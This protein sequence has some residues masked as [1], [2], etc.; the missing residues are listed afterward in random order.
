MMTTACGHPVSGGKVLRYRTTA[1]LLFAVA[2]LTT[3]GGTGES[4]GQT[5]VSRVGILTFFANKDDP[6]LRLWLEP[7][8]RTLADRG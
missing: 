8:R 6:T 7:F 1:V 2:M 5:N 3:L 4:W